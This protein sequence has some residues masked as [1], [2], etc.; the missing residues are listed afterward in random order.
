[1]ADTV[2]IQYVLQYVSIIN[3]CIFTRFSVMDGAIG[4]M[5][6]LLVTTTYVENI[7]RLTGD[8]ACLDSVGQ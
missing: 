7:K 6:W 5:V 3:C 1:M 2:T 4:L 8:E